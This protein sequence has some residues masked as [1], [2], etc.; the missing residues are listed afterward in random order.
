MI[1]DIQS[2]N[3]ISIA[4]FIEIVTTLAEQGEK[5]SLSVSY[6]VSVHDHGL[7]ANSD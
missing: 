6:P 5:I 3:E 1:P 2:K 7:K 4:A